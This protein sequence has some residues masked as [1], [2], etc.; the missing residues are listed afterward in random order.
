MN[1]SSSDETHLFTIKIE[2]KQETATH[3]LACFLI[4]P[5]VEY[6]SNISVLRSQDDFNTDQ[7]AVA[8]IH[9]RKHIHLVSMI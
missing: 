4:S 7:E 2:V 9:R 5:N 3:T 6:L 8:V 1:T